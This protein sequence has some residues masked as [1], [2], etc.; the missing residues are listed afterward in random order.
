MY[1]AVLA[2]ALANQ[3]R[4][5]LAAIHLAGGWTAAESTSSS[6]PSSSNAGDFRLSAS[7]GWSAELSADRDLF[8]N[9]QIE[10]GIAHLVHDVTF[11]GAG[12]A[13]RDRD[14]LN[15]TGVFAGVR[16]TLL[17][18]NGLRVSLAPRALFASEDTLKAHLG[19]ESFAAALEPPKAAAGLDLR[20]TFPDCPIDRLWSLET[21]VAGYDLL[22]EPRGQDTRGWHLNSLQWYLGVSY[23]HRARQPG[24]RCP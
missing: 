19:N 14:F 12:D 10:T 7:G 21:G 13:F 18:T 16:F 17:R 15:L 3:E 1:L 5:G 4:V 23:R 9:V 22:L 2:G 20:L 8:R 11:A 24:R 6:W